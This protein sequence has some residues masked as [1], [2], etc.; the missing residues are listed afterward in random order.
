MAIILYAITKD[1]YFC[2]K[3]TAD[4]QIDDLAWMR[5]PTDR[6]FF[7]ELTTLQANQPILVGYKTAQVMPYLKDRKLITISS[8]KEHGIRL[9]QAL[10]RYPEGIVIGGASILRSAMNFSH[11]DYINSIITVRLPLRVP[12]DD[13]ANYIKDP[14]LPFKDSE[15]LKLS[16]Q[17]FLYTDNF[18]QPTILVEIW[19]PTYN[20]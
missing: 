13:A 7:R 14:L 15:I 2:K 4:K 3:E 8:R 6:R 11:R 9:D 5:I 20:E 12:R 18:E 10:Q 16:S 17:F 1:N 19:R